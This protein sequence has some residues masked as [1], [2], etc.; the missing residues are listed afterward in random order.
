M[1]KSTIILSSVLLPGIGICGGELE[2]LEKI[3][4]RGSNNRKGVENAVKSK[5]ILV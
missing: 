4:K 5:I 2:T 1:Q 3:N